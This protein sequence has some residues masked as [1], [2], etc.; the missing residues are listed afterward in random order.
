MREEEIVIKGGHSPAFVFLILSSF[1]YVIVDYFSPSFSPSMMFFI[2]FTSQFS[3][4]INID[5]L[6]RQLFFRQ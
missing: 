5:R 2:A 6:Q 1:L 4:I 3:Y